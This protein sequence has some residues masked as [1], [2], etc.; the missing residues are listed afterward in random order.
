MPNRNHLTYMNLQ[1]GPGAY[2][3]MLCGSPN[4]GKTT[5]Y[6]A[7]RSLGESDEDTRPTTNILYGEIAIG[8]DDE[9]VLALHDTPGQMTYRNL[10]PQC[11]H[12]TKVIY[13][14]FDLSDR[15][16][17]DELDE[18]YTFLLDHIRTPEVIVIVVGNKA[19]LLDDMD[20][21]SEAEEIGNAFARKNDVPIILISAKLRYG[22]Q[23]LINLT[24][25]KIQY[26]GNV[27]TEQETSIFAE[28]PSDRSCC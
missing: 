27:Y 20:V 18:W 15:K 2:K 28:E 19:D 1:K 8:E 10:I 21:P 26:S 25:E 17:A 23:E 14:L 16:S 5:L 12:N 4:T 22:L 7:F 3:V 24:R 9:M 11:L 6:N 13:L